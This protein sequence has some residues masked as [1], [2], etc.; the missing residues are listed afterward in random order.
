M[1]ISTFQLFPPE[2]IQEQTHPLPF[3]FGS[4]L[5][6]LRNDSVRAADAV[7]YIAMNYCSNWQS[8]KTHFLSQAKIA[9]MLGLPR[10]FVRK[11]LKRMSRYLK[12]LKTT[13]KGSRYEVTKHAYDSDTIDETDLPVDD[14]GRPLTFAVPYGYGSPIDRMFRGQ[15]SW[16]A[17]LVWIVLRFNSDWRTGESRPTN[18][19]KLASQCRLG[20]QTICDAIK[21]LEKL[22]LVVRKTKMNEEAIY[23]LFPKPKSK[24]KA[25]SKDNKSADGNETATHWYS[26]N[27]Q[28]RCSKENAVIEKRISKKKWRPVRECDF[29]TIPLPISLH[30]NAKIDCERLRNSF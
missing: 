22:G 2:S 23:Q 15:L 18:H 25:D 10:R 11:I 14:N 9:D 3:G 16:Q 12:K 24:K 27:Y 20:A 17:C 4:I 21:E 30:F 5:S 29:H 7:L 8:S 26:N 6:E 19:L 13:R 28:Y 1:T